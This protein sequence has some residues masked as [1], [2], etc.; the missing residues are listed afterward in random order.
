[1]LWPEAGFTKGQVIDYYARIAEAILPHLRD[2]PLTLKRYPNGVAESY[3]YEKRCPRHRPD[4]VETVPIWSGRNE[5]EIDYCLC[6]DRATLIWLAQLAALELHPS[7]SLAD[8][9]E[10]PTVLAFDLDP[11]APADILDC[12]GIALRLRELFAGLELECFPKTSGSKGLQVYVPLNSN[13]TYE[14]T[15]PFAR[16]VAQALE[17]AKPDLVVSRMAKNLR[18]GKVLVDWSQNDQHKTTVCVYSLRAKERPTVSTPIAWKEVEEAAE[19]EDRELLSFEADEVLKRVEKQGDL[20]APVLELR[21]ELP[22]SA[23]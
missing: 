2:R 4:W 7:L 10:R 5:G 1:M 6:N 15:K 3:F 20:F 13:V 16:A 12:C 14:E 18:K 23:G 21:Q 19:R 17:R 8:E 11:G 22:E 9:I